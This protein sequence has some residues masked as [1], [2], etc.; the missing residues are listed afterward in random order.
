MSKTA[1]RRHRDSSVRRAS[2][3]GVGGSSERRRPKFRGHLAK[4]SKQPMLV[5]LAPLYRRNALHACRLAMQSADPCETQ[6]F[7]AI[8]ERWVILAE[9]EEVRPN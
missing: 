7:E 2:T 5:S 6:I 9:S 4:G 1:L 8:A 3:A